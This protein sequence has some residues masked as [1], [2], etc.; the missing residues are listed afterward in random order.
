LANSGDIL[1][2]ISTSGNS[3]NIIEVLKKSKQIKCK[4]ISLLGKGGGTAKRFSDFNLVIKSKNTATI[5]EAHMFIMHYILE[6]VEKK[7]MKK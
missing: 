2:S 3:K 4:S 6:I 1:I 5:Q 7:L